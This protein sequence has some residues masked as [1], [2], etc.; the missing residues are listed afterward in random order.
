MV[1]VRLVSKEGSLVFKTSSSTF[2]IQG[3]GGFGNNLVTLGL[4]L[5]FCEME[6]MFHLAGLFQG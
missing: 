6:V 5:L 3:F 4:S 2:L 1:G